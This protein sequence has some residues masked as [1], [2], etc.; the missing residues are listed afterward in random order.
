MSRVRRIDS[1]LGDE[2]WVGKLTLQFPSSE[3]VTVWPQVIPFFENPIIK[4]S[5][6]PRYMNYAVVGRAS[7]LFAYLGSDSR[8]LDVSFNM[9][10]P[11]V[12]QVSTGLVSTW[13]TPPSKLEKKREILSKDALSAGGMSQEGAETMD[14]IDKSLGR[15]GGVAEKI[16]KDYHNVLNDEEKLLAAAMSATSPI[17]APRSDGAKVRR[18]SIN[19]IASLVALIRSTVINNS[20]NIALGPPLVRLDWG[21]LYRDVPCVCK[22]YNIQ[23]NDKAGYDKRTL[24][25]RVLTVNMQLE[26]VRKLHSAGA[27]ITKDNIAGWE[28]LFTDPAIPGLTMDPGNFK[29]DEVIQE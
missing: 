25:P 2:N 1:H 12:R 24:L 4:E 17:Y 3:G 9:T 19:Q 13:D 5:Q 7:N 6:T 15:G 10:L 21:I 18:R 20:T 23:V 26:E 11:N 8:R 27:P 29:I 16:D 28:V 22:G 14:N